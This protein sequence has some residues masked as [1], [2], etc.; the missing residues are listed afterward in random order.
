[1]DW[2]L[3]GSSIHGS[4]YRFWWGEGGKH[5][6]HSH[7][8]AGN[9]LNLG[10]ILGNVLLKMSEHRAWRS[11]WCCSGDGTLPLDHLQ[12]KWEPSGLLMERSDA[13]RSFKESEG[14]LGSLSFCRD[15]VPWRGVLTYFPQSFRPLPEGKPREGCCGSQ[16]KEGP[17]GLCA[18]DEGG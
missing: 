17:R 13:R 18:K 11:P 12:L 8:V 2:S 1:M 10:C 3:P 7:L 16:E 5:S 6:G 4:T 14:E 15:C 9:S